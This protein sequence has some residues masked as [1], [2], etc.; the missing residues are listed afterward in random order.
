M[1][2]YYSTIGAWW[3]DTL[4]RHS[5][6]DAELKSH[7]AEH[8]QKT[9][10]YSHV[11]KTRSTFCT[12]VPRY[13]GTYTWVCASTRTTTRTDVAEDISTETCTIVYNCLTW[14]ESQGYVMVVQ[15]NNECE[16]HFAISSLCTYSTSIPWFH[17]Y[18][19]IISWVFPKEFI[20]RSE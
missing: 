14:I 11:Y 9:D 8:G 16:L 17:R 20:I 5:R 1:W 19:R 12:R 2:Y 7:N 15:L 10:V 13:R 6:D 18:I 3:I 4:T